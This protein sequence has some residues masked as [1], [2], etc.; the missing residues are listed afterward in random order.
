MYCNVLNSKH[1]RADCQAGRVQPL[2]IATEAFTMI[3][4]LPA[5][6]GG[7]PPRLPGAGR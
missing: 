5:L 3:T 1:R 4:F 2:P 7:G 6:E